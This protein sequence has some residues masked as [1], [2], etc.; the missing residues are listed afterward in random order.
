MLLAG[1][2]TTPPAPATT[3]PGTSTELLPL[4]ATRGTDAAL[5]D[6]AGRQVTLR[7]ANFNQLGDYFVTD[8][9]L[10]TVAT[11][12]AA[13]WDDARAYGFNV[14]RLV[15]SWS[16]WEPVRGEYDLTYAQKVKDAVAEANAHGIYALVD[17]H[18]DAW[19]KFVY[20]PVDH[21]CPAGWSRTRGWDGAPEW[22]TFTDGQETCSPDGKREN[23]PAVQQAWDNF[24]GNRE[25]VRDAYA[26]LWGFIGRQFAGNPG[27]AGFDLLNEP[28]VGSSVDQA[29]T[30]LALA[31]DA[32]IRQ[33]RLAERTFAPG[34]ST[35][36]A[37][38]EPLFGGFPL[39]PFDF[40]TDTNVVFAPHTYAESFD[41][42]AGELDFVLNAY[43]TA[44]RAAY[45]APVFLGEYGAYRGGPFN[46]T[47]TSRVHRLVADNLYAGDTWWQWEQS[48]GDPHNTSYPLSEDEVLR[49][50]PGCAD[51][52]S[53]QACP[54][55]PYPRAVPGRLTS[56]DASVCGSGTLTVTGTTSA[57]STADLWFPT[58]S[59][60]AP[61]VT[62]DGIGTV[63][64]QQQAGGW[65]VFVSVDGAYRISVS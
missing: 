20:S 46:Q 41:D 54:T 1:A 50:L 35:H 57:Q 21:P 39:I 37:F 10:P 25:G 33:I 26:E 51:S 48:C 14:V 38:V 23:S 63:T 58:S 65:R 56:I 12:D 59:D 4:T 34:A 53:I 24:Y 29:T 15:T 52:R 49:R 36:A 2:C 55:R 7:G 61:T 22:A 3:D 18:Q 27:V 13:D 43:G 30:G 62:G 60:T 42:I 32:A 11:L 45:R 16:A 5:Y 17:L 8:P 47:W 40:S 31:Y 9:R 44:A 64:T 28:G 19:G 6:S